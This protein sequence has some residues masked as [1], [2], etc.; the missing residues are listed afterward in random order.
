MKRIFIAVA[1][2]A[3]AGAIPARATTFPSLTLIYVASGVIE[4]D[5]SNGSSGIGTVISCSNMSAQTAS[6]RFVFRRNDGR[7][8]AGGTLLLG[9]LASRAVTTEGTTSI[10]FPATSLPTGGMFGGSI[11]IL[12]TQSAVFCSAMVFHPGGNVAGPGPTGCRA[13][14]GAVQPASGNSGVSRGARC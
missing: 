12:S 8:A 11:Q 10:L 14:H 6:V 7:I 4:N 13:A 1:A 3:L 9:S 5:L 2:V